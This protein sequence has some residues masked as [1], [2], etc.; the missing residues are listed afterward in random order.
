MKRL[1]L[2]VLVLAAVSFASAKTLT[3]TLVLD[4]GNMKVYQIAVTESLSTTKACTTTALP[5]LG[6][7]DSIRV[8]LNGWSRAAVHDT[9]QLLCALQYG[10]LSTGT[11]MG[12]DSTGTIV[13]ADIITVYKKNCGALTRDTGIR[14]TKVMP[15]H[16]CP[17]T[18]FIITG[19]A[20]NA[21]TV[22]DLYI[23]V[24]QRR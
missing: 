7:T 16:F 2:L 24:Y 21:W 5:L 11:W 1:I 23:A 15:A 14:A 4:Q 12:T 18:R 3:P 19:L 8:F 9:V 13:T 17:F 22:F 20:E 6:Q 10:A